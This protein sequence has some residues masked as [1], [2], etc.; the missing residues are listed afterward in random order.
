VPESCQPHLG[1][2]FGNTAGLVNIITSAGRAALAGGLLLGMAGCHR[3]TTSLPLV[4]VPAQQSSSAP[5]VL[6]LSGDGNW[7][8][9]PRE[10]GNALAA[11]GAPVLGLRSRSYFL[12][13]HTPAQVAR[14]LERAV[15]HYLQV[16]D[17]SSLVLVG[18]SRGADVVPFVYNRWPADLQRRVRGMMLVGM[19]DYAGFKFH[20]PDL[21]FYVRWPAELPLRPELRRIAD[22]PLLCVR[23]EYED[24][25]FCSHP[26][27][28]MQVL[29]HQGGHTVWGD[30]ALIRRL[31]D[32]V[33]DY[34][35][36]STAPDIS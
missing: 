25:S 12:T 27:P 35:R 24:N 4:I 2:H 18:Y 6:L 19:H 7:T 31:V 26:V 22:V 16:W 17:R 28:G 30:T 20:L 36:A 34:Q 23:G 21:L 3:T 10:L 11:R 5:L 13:W 8:T 1:G 32:Q 33:M 29:R 14:D 9:F 15:R